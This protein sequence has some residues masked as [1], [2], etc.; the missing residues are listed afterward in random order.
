MKNKYKNGNKQRVHRLK[1]LEPSLRVLRNE[2]KYKDTTFTPVADDIGFVGFF[3]TPAQGLGSNQR[4]ADRIVIGDLDW[5]INYNLVNGAT[6]LFR[7]IIFQS[8]GLE[9]QA[10][11]PA[12][13]DILETPSPISPYKYNSNKQFHILCDVQRTLSKNGDS[14]IILIKE[15]CKPVQS[16]LNFITASLNV[17]SGQLWYLI[18]GTQPLGNVVNLHARCWF[19][20]TD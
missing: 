1:F 17:Y 13:V 12:V 14:S 19:S 20:D 8:V 5:M 6:D 15:R 4:V 11:P 2:W 16:Q 9:A 10:T 7:I 18:I 3:S